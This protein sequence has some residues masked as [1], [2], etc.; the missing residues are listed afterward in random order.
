MKDNTLDSDLK[1]IDDFFDSLTIEQFED[2]LEKA[3]VD[4][5][6]SYATIDEVLADMSDEERANIQSFTPI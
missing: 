3:M 1:K 4:S 6:D 5:L 2:M